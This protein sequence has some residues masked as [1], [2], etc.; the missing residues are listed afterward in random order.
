MRILPMRRRIKEALF[1]YLVDCFGYG[2]KKFSTIFNYVYL[3][4]FKRT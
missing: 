2:N 3:H 1:Q 4:I